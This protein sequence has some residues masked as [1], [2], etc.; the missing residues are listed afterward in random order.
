MYEM[1]I[2]CVVFLSIAELLLVARLIEHGTHY[3]NY[4]SGS[5]SFNTE[6]SVAVTIFTVVFVGIGLFTSANAL[7]DEYV[8]RNPI[9]AEK[10]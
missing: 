7:R 4:S 3:N 6:W 1:L 8:R 2:V 10:P 9:S 5:G